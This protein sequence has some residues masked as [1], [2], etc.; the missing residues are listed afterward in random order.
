[1]L[2][3]MNPNLNP[4]NQPQNHHNIGLMHLWF[5]LIYMDVEPIAADH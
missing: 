5:K 1:M 2:T 3:V 4:S